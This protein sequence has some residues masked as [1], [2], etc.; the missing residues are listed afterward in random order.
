[1]DYILSKPLN[2]IK[3]YIFLFAVFFG[4]NAKAQ[5]LKNGTINRKALVS[6]HKLW[7]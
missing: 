5:E 7:L 1:M 4:I 6:R 3:K 2:K